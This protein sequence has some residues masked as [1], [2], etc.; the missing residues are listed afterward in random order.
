M[1]LVEDPA[2]PV[3]APDDVAHL[4]SSLRVRGGETVLAADGR[5]TWTRCRVAGPPGERPGADGAALLVRDG[6]VV[7]EAA[8]EVAL[9]VAFTP[10]KGDRPEWVVQK[11]TELGVD[12]IV[13]LRTARSVVRWDG[14]RAGRSLARLRRIAREAA[15]QARRA[16]LPEVT[17][18]MT[19]A[20][21]AGGAPAGRP[22]LAERG[23]APPSL[24]HPVVA[25]GPE[26]GWEPSEIG[27][28][29][30]T[31]G[32]GP[33]VLRAETA[34]VTIGAVLCALRAGMVAPAGR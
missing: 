11:L 28:G 5:G 6:P 33:N 20:E 9:T 21:L 27:G 10:V 13:P 17:D 18:I 15:A 29:F 7:V 24:D 25:I 22:A 19:V 14:D 26:G 1:V 32:L 4:V 31:V 16:W 23:G 12:R 34:A 8:P 3:V 2:G 30:A